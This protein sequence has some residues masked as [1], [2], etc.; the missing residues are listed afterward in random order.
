MQIAGHR[1][2][3]EF[4]FRI[5]DKSDRVIFLVEEAEYK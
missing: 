3:N 1:K 2:N 4:L 5:C